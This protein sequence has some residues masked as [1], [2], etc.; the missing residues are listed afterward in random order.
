MAKRWLVCGLMVLLPVS[1]VLAQ[2]PATDPPATKDDILRLFRVMDT[3][4]QVRQVME[5]VMQQMRV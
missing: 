1:V 4:A 3:Q 2:P 5:Q